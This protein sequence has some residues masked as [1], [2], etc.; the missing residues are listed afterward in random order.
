MLKLL[1]RPEDE[2]LR[3]V[4]VDIFLD[5]FVELVTLPQCKQV[6]VTLDKILHAIEAREKIGIQTTLEDLHVLPFDYADHK[7][8]S[9]LP[10]VEL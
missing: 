5:N 1:F 8:S 6:G 10:K 7:S 9:R 3:I 2:A 4:D